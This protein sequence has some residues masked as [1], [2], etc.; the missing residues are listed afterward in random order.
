M[1]VMFDRFAFL[2]RDAHARLRGE[3]LDGSPR[4]ETITVTKGPG[5]QPTPYDARDPLD[6]PDTKTTK[7]SKL[8]PPVIQ[9]WVQRL[10]FMQQSV[11]LS[12]IRG[13]DGVRK[14]HPCKPL[15]RWYRRCVL[16]SAFEGKAITNPFSPGGGSFTGPIGDVSSGGQ[17]ATFEADWPKYIRGYVDDYLIARDELPYHFQVHLMHAF[18]IIGY[19]HP[20][21]TIR[22]F[23]NQVYVRIVEAM[24]LWPEEP[25]ELAA[26]LGDNK[27]QWLARADVTERG[28]AV[29]CSE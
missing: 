8:P 26:R 14:Q 17:L 11:L 5:M 20:D 2:L 16:I 6:W 13:P 29:T 24:H 12:G 28:C 10:S 9:E 4:R 7:A 21:Q 3:N 23:W 18:E 25:H 1:D 27:A 19:C 15:L 22:T